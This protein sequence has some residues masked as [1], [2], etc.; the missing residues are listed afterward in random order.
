M[1]VLQHIL[2]TS[3]H[4]SVLLSAMAV[5]KTSPSSDNPQILQCLLQ[6]SFIESKGD[7]LIGEMHQ[8]RALSTAAQRVCAQWMLHASPAS[9][10]KSLQTIGLISATENAC[11]F[12]MAKLGK[13]MSDENAPSDKQPMEMIFTNDYTRG[14]TKLRN[15]LDVADLV[16]PEEGHH[17]ALASTKTAP[18][19]VIGTLDGNGWVHIISGCAGIWRDGENDKSIGTFIDAAGKYIPTP[20]A[21]G[22]DRP[23]RFFAIPRRKSTAHELVRMLRE[24]CCR[25]EWQ[26]E[27]FPII[28]TSFGQF[29]EFIQN[30]HLCV[31]QSELEQKMQH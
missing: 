19:Y 15:T 8:K 22:D 25:K 10:T 16:R 30:S 6:Y 9:V 2:T 4:V 17:A 31:D 12:L 11:Q 13:Q 1:E 26:R 29:S 18:Q 28:L 5:L 23:S 3:K 24:L 14:G 7:D 21:F 20:G 27:L